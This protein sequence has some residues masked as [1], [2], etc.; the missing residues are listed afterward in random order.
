M[1]RLLKT[2]AIVFLSALPAF[3]VT[4]F[5]HLGVSAMGT[6]SV[7]ITFT[8]SGSIASQINWGVGNVINVVGPDSAGTTHSFV[9][10]GLSAGKV[11][12]YQAQAS[13]G[14]TSATQ[15]FALCDSGPNQVPMQGKVNSYY[16]YGTYTLTFTDTNS[17]GGT[18]TL[19]GTAIG[20]LPSGSLDYLG[21][22]TATVPDNLKTVPSP[23]TWA[24][25]VADVG[26]I[27]TFTIQATATGSS[28]DISA[29]LQAAASGQLQFVWYNP[30]TSTFYPALSGGGGTPGGSSGQLQFN[31]AGAFGGTAAFTYASNTISS[32][33]S[34]V[35]DLHLSPVTTGLYF[36][37]AAGAAPTAAGRGAYDTT[38]NRLKHGDGTTTQTVVDQSDLSSF[39]GVGFLT[40]IDTA[41]PPTLAN[42]TVS[43]SSRIT[44]TNPAG[45]AGNPSADIVASSI[46]PT[47]LAN[48]AVTPGSYTN[49]NMTVDAQGRITAAS[50]GTGGAGGYTSTIVAET[51]SWTAATTD[52]VT[53]GALNTFVFTLAYTNGTQ[54]QTVTLP[55]HNAGT[56]D[57]ACANFQNATPSGSLPKAPAT[58]LLITAPSS[59]LLNG[60]S[61]DTAV[62]WPGDSVQICYKSS[63]DN[64]YATTGKLSYP[65]TNCTNNANASA[66]GNT[67]T[68]VTAN[69]VHTYGF[70]VPNPGCKFSNMYVAS[71]AADASGSGF[72]I[73]DTSGKFWCHN[74][75]GQTTSAN[76]IN[77]FAC[78]E[79]TVYLAPGVYVTA[80]TTGSGSAT[81]N[82]YS[83][84]VNTYAGTNVTG[85][86]CGSTSNGTFSSTSACTIPSATPS[87][88]VLNC[89]GIYLQ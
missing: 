86:G 4:T 62:I 84:T 41:T 60:V 23:S 42:R 69:N 32:T 2:L 1:L 55:A 57:T 37:S 34:G 10:S 3:A 74:A 31:N 80:W 50:N 26:S 72:A 78:T 54:S 33:S 67:T 35:L 71:A 12:S 79:G 68:A 13:D 39:P 14:S 36:P 46:G 87:R 76:V 44:W 21:S 28:T 66:S 9:V 75:S 49:T 40:Q 85:G 89:P 18:P 61:A 11:Y 64:Y 59:V 77:T 48:T 58:P 25:A 27:G 52:F 29:A 47:Q 30:A 43:N 82:G 88:P 73:L 19:C 51:A 16:L 53:T 20:S 81:Y 15:K 83:V 5:T 6:S 7:T 63:T 17:V 65:L 8:T 56:A 38:V 22:F 24:V 70:T 45:T